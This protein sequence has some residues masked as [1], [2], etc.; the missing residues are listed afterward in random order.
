MQ[1]TYLDI[2]IEGLPSDL[3]GTILVQASDIHYKS[4]DPQIFKTVQDFVDI[5]NKINPDLT[6]LTGDYISSQEG[7]EN[8]ENLNS[9]GNLLSN[10]NN[11][12]GTYACL[13]NHD[14]KH[15]LKSSCIEILEHSGVSVLWNQIAEPLG[16]QLPLVGLADFLSPDFNLNCFSGISEDTPRI[17]LAHNPDSTALFKDKEVRA[18][19]I[20]SGH[21]H[22]GQ[23]Q[24]PW[25]GPLLPLLT[26]VLKHIP[27]LKKYTKIVLNLKLFEGLH[28]LS[29]GNQIYI[30]R[31]LGSH[32]PGRFFCAPEVTVITLKSSIRDSRL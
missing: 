1:V 27:K 8:L 4:D 14:V 22:G 17:V 12:C 13:G 29:L 30:N 5:N 15:S 25:V 3:H 24:L 10:L 31:G 20:L 2:E 28:S 6:V 23:I 32:F 26:P 9:L 21:T 18:D 19:L 7:E 16:P 11:K